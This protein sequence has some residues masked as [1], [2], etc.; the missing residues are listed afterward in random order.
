MCDEE[1]WNSTVSR[2]GSYVS[3]MYGFGW[4]QLEK[5]GITT[6]YK[7]SETISHLQNLEEVAGLQECR[8]SAY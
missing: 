3:W 7:S 6:V 4:L 2:Q 8:L 5:N 1:F